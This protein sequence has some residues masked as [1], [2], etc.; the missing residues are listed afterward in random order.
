MIRSSYAETPQV[1]LS[2][3]TEYH[4]RSLSFTRGGYAAPKDRSN[5]NVDVTASDGDVEK[6]VDNEGCFDMEKLERVRKE[7]MGSEASL[8]PNN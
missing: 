1:R 8:S 2:V 4:A 3:K 5:R 7:F 6:S